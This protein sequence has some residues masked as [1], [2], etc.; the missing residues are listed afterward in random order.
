LLHRREAYEPGRRRVKTD[1]GAD[2]V[3]G[4]MEIPKR[5]ARG[6]SPNP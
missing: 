3:A 1:R 2:P 6:G 5:I 4:P